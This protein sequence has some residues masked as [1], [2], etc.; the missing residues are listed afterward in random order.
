[1][2][3]NYIE[4]RSN[5]SCADK[6]RTRRNILCYVLPAFVAF[7][8]VPGSGL[9]QNGW[10]ARAARDELRPEFSF[11]ASGGPD[12]NGLLVIETNSQSG[13]DGCWAKSFKGKFGVAIQIVHQRH[14]VDRV[15]PIEERF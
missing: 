15:N 3:C 5:G 11:D 6:R 4:R 12:G 2:T 10:Q 14:E 9:A 8:T 7:A 13:L 1:M